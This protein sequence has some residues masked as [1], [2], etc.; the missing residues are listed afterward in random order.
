MPITGKDFV[1]RIDSGSANNDA[2]NL[3]NSDPQVI[4]FEFLGDGE[5][6]LDTDPV[7]GLPIAG[8][9]DP[10]TTINITSGFIDPTNQNPTGTDITGE[11]NFTISVAGRLPVPNSNNPKF[12]PE[13]AGKI[14]YIIELTDDVS[15]P[16]IDN[17]ASLNGVLT[18]SVSSMM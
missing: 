13:F 3:D 9:E 17:D 2:I 5:L 16:L 4:E 10:N 6:E 8:S 14:V 11:Y 7:T 1:G 15:T 12:P 18:S